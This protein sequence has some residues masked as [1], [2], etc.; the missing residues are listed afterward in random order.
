MSDM[1]SH[2]LIEDMSDPGEL[3]SER[4]VAIPMPPTWG[5]QFVIDR[6]VRQP[7]LIL[8]TKYKLTEQNEVIQYEGVQFV[9]SSRTTGVH[10]FGS[11]C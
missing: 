10:F 11:G 2:N 4:L 6:L 8:T 5:L 7:G 1:S 9:H 3:L